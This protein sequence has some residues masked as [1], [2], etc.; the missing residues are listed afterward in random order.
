MMPP[1]ESE[2]AVVRNMQDPSLQ[3]ECEMS[4]QITVVVSVFLGMVAP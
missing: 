1:L 2:V 3:H 4:Q